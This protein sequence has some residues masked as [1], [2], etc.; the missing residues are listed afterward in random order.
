MADT[1][2]IKTLAKVI[3]AAAWADDQ[4]THDEI[5]SLKDLLFVLPD[6]TA[7]QWAELEM[8]IE[9][10]VTQPEREQLLTE[11]Q[12]A[13]S[14]EADKKL[15]FEALD[16]M[17]NADGT[18]TE[19][20]RRIAQEIRSAVEEADTGIFSQLTSLVRGP[21][22]RR[23]DQVTKTY[24]RERYFDDFV[25]NKVYYGVRRR[26]DLGKEQLALPDET[27]RKL[28]LAGGLLARVARVTDGITPSETE[29]IVKALQTGWSISYEEAS[30]VADVAVAEES[31]NIDYFRVTREFVL[32][33]EL[34]ERK[35]F[36][37]A[38][39]A[40]AAA[41]GMIS[42]DEMNEI[43]EIA[44]SIKLSNDT[45]FEGEVKIPREKRLE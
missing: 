26:L 28:G 15:A 44:R 27:L 5:N 20:E 41:D 43:R 31:Q 12:S 3:I 17:L 2:L 34:D 32:L 25:K 7:L 8:Y 18:I 40:V 39:F 33:C 24:N 11:L 10:P 1:T 21:I 14:T 38:L 29:S 6:L 36:L 9:T 22:S 16:N 4:I 37:E 35:Q 23:N 45:F 42:T 30:V 13:I 19:E